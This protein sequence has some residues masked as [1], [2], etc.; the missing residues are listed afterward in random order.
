MDFTTRAIVDLSAMG[1]VLK[2]STRSVGP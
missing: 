1:P 2:R